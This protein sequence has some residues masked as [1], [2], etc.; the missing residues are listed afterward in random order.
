MGGITLARMPLDHVG[1][2]V[3]DVASAKEYYESL[4]PLVGFKP[5]SSGRD[6]IS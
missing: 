5:F 4:V 6:W 3:P 1:I 2:N